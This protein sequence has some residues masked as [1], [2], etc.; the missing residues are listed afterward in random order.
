MTAKVFKTSGEK[1]SRDVTSGPFYHVR[2]SSETYHLALCFHLCK[3]LAVA[4]CSQSLYRNSY[5]NP[6][7][8]TAK[9]KKTFLLQ[10]C[11]LSSLFDLTPSHPSFISL[12]L[13]TPVEYLQVLPMSTTL[14]FLPHSLPLPIFGELPARTATWL[15]VVSLN[16]LGSST[17]RGPLS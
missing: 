3:R 15:S 10:I 9:K 7:S 11:T 16:M 17:P 12:S 4:D 13:R 2:F 1:T 6:L 14:K 8:G 5:T